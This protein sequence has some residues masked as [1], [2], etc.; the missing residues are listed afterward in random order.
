MSVPFPSSFYW[1]EGVRF[2]TGFELYLFRFCYKRKVFG[3]LQ[4]A[5]NYPG[6]QPPDKDN[7]SMVEHLT[8]SCKA[9]YKSLIFMMTRTLITMLL[10]LYQQQDNMLLILKFEVLDIDSCWNLIFMLSI[11]VCV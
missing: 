4:H 8:V 7:A 1:V 6:P 3:Q 5:R 9:S 10:F 11:F 2:A